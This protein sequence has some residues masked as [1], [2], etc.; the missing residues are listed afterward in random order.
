MILILTNMSFLTTF[1]ADIIWSSWSSCSVTCGQG[2]QERT[3]YCPSDKEGVEWKECPKLRHSQPRSRPCSQGNC[4]GR[5]RQAL[6]IYWESVSSFSF[7]GF[8]LFEIGD[9]VFIYYFLGT[10]SSS[11]C[12]PISCLSF[13]ITSLNLSFG[14]PVFRCPLTSIFPFSLQCLTLHLSPHCLNLPS[15][16]SG[17][18][19]HTL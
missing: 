10:F 15:T 7:F 3:A 17:S 5:W 2:T 6:A 16:M 9:L 1:D 4:P 11:F 13:R 12:I 18:H 14:L 8:S 19:F